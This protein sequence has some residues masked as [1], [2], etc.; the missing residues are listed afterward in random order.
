[1]R[2][3]TLA[4]KED[5]ASAF[6]EV[7][8]N[9][10]LKDYNLSKYFEEVNEDN[11]EDSYTIGEPGP[12]LNIYRA[13]LFSHHFFQRIDASDALCLMCDKTRGERRIMK[14]KNG[15]IKGMEGHLLSQHPEFAEK[16]QKV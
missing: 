16:Y 12:K 9:K 8:W 14:H 5:T 4:R 10:K 3:N 13:L 2:N 1:M 15:N 6:E 11:K 7:D